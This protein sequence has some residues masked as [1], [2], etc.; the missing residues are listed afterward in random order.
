MNFFTRILTGA[1][2]SLICLSAAN[3]E[4]YDKN[5]IGTFLSNFTECDY[6]NITREEMIESRDILVSF[7]MCHLDIN[8]PKQFKDVS[9]CDKHPKECSYG[10]KKI[11]DKAVAKVIKRYLAYDFNDF[12]PTDFH[13]YRNNYF[14]MS[15][16]AKELLYAAVVKNI[17]ALSNGNL[18][19]TAALYNT[20]TEKKP[21]ED[22]V[23]ITA[24][25]KPYVW[26]GK[27]TWSLVSIKTND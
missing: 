25:I 17:Y 7:A 21:S 8:A 23:T 3:A 26:D 24:E 6:L 16:G 13:Q 15:Y 2:C 10:D 20:V 9:D 12:Q 14:Y 1:C 18:K 27:K 5:K 22:A 11:S 4:N 19:V